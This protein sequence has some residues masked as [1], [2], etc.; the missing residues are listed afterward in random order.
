MATGKWARYQ[1]EVAK[2]ATGKGCPGVAVRNA[3]P[4]VNQQG[5]AIGAFCVALQ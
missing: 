4:T 2:K 5:E 3:P 1:G